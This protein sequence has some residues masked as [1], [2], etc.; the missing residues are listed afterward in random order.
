MK[1]HKVK[2]FKLTLYSLKTFG[3]LHS[4]VGAGAAL[5]MIRPRETGRVCKS[6]KF[7]GFFRAIV[8]FGEIIPLIMSLH[9]P[10]LI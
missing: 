7:H 2:F 10:G 8:F 5:R 3:L 4:R 6:M 9:I 1:N